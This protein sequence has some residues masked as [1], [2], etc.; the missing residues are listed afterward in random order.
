MSAEVRVD[1]L[2]LR[3]AATVFAYGGVL[4]LVLRV[5]STVIGTLS[6]ARYSL[7]GEL[8][9]AMLA[10]VAFVTYRIT[11]P[12]EAAKWMG[13]LALSFYFG[14]WAHG[15]EDRRRAKAGQKTGQ[16]APSTE[17]HGTD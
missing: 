12:F 9:V 4:F 13:V 5:L 6:G 3:F 14:D 16:D 15:L 1:R 11:D 8:T 2:E 7:R 10:I 17:R